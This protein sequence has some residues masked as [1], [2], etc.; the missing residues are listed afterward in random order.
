MGMPWSAWSPWSSCGLHSLPV[1]VV[2]PGHKA[3]QVVHA[4]AL[5]A[6]GCQACHKFLV[7][8]M[9]KDG[10]IFVSPNAQRWNKSHQ[11]KSKKISEKLRLAAE[12]A[13]LLTR[14]LITTSLHFSEPIPMCSTGQVVCNPWDS[15]YGGYDPRPI[16]AHF[17]ELEDAF[18][19]G[20]GCSSSP[21]KYRPKASSVHLST[22]WVA[23]KYMVFVT[24]GRKP[25]PK[26]HKKHK[27]TS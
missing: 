24:V 13:F 7:A 5:V 17:R 20:H 16:T 1:F 25:P 9:V 18:F 12:L 6:M 15:G 21:P 14:K 23:P 22:A 27:R 10:V 2:N 11:N 19:T 8:A 3:L 26:K 4:A